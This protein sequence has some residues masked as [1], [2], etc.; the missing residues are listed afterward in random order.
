M[1]M[2]NDSSVR[3]IAI[4]CPYCGKRYR[5]VPY[6]AIKKYSSAFCKQCKAK[7][8]ITAAELEEALQQALP[9]SQR[10]IP[11]AQAQAPESPGHDQA[12]E[13]KITTL[14]ATMEET[15]SRPLATEESNVA[16]QDAEEKHEEA[17]STKPPSGAEY[18][19]AA[20]VAARGTDNLQIES[21]PDLTPPVENDSAAPAKMQEVHSAE[22]DQ[23]ICFDSQDNAD[24]TVPV[25]TDIPAAEPET[26][27]LPAHPASPTE[28]GHGAEEAIPEVQLSSDALLPAPEEQPAQDESMG[29]ELAFS[30]PGMEACPVAPRDDASGEPDTQHAL[31]QD[32]AGTPIE[33]TVPLEQLP[34]PDFAE[35]LAEKNA[36]GVPFGE[37]LPPSMAEPLPFEHEPA[38]DETMADDSLP[39]DSCPEA[40]QTAR[41]DELL[42]RQPETPE[43]EAGAPPWESGDAA[44]SA[45]LM[46]AAQEEE[47]LDESLI[48]DELEP[49]TQEGLS[50]ETLLEDLLEQK[51]AGQAEE[52]LSPRPEAS[53]LDSLEDADGNRDV[54][55]MLKQLA[56][57]ADEIE[58]GMEQFV[59]FSLGQQTF[60]APIA[61]VFELS[62]PPEL[63]SVP[64]TPSWIRG[65]SNMRGEI[66]SVVDLKGFMNIAPERFKKPTRMIIAQTLDKD[67]IL[68]LLVDSIKCIK[69]FSVETIQ[70]LEQHEPGLSD[71]F[72][73]G[74]C[75]DEAEAVIF[76]DLEQILQSSK[77]RQFQ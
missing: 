10:D 46:A 57:P 22:A 64:N 28:N 23:P 72:F 32:E 15:F 34:A 73:L 14:A 58:E 8:H 16:Q 12:L 31:A 1:L 4:T 39:Q 30:A 50:R 51:Q 27:G 65:I 44:P 53:L 49:F 38:A 3:H 45:D 62:L 29:P 21:L 18:T 24:Q 76:L 70:P 35:G 60:A 26:D 2:Q 75:M 52:S 69:Y 5:K 68:G 37:D 36:A 54:S 17:P 71:A 6:E 41:M 48:E 59:L 40:A 63:I 55:A 47:F 11:A 77:M 43:N 67:M 61:N 66:I 7:F 33:E 9:A 74:A 13:Q 42:S 20:A 25:S 56:L 19:P